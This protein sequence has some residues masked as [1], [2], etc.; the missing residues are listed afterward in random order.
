M[1][2]EFVSPIRGGGERLMD[3]ADVEIDNLR[4]AFAWSRETTDVQK[5]LRLA[6]ALQPFWLAGALPGRIGL[7]RR[8]R[9]R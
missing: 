7:V 6:S 5:G 1:A 8:R 3:W 9:D 2:T 4:A